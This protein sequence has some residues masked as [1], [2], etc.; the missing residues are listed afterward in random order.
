VDRYPDDPDLWYFWALLLP[1]RGLFL[2][3]PDTIALRRGAVGL[4]RVLALDSTYLEALEP[5]ARMTYQLGDTARGKRYSEQYLARAPTGPE[6]ETVRCMLAAGAR[7]LAA[8]PTLVAR[9][10]SLGAYA[11]RWCLFNLHAMP[12]AS[13]VRDSVADHLGRRYLAD[14][15][16]PGNDGMM[17]A[18][19]LWM[20][21]ADRGRPAEAVG[22][23][24]AMRAAGMGDTLRYLTSRI[25]DALYWEGDGE[26]ADRAATAIAEQVARQFAE[27]QGSHSP[28]DRI[29]VE[30]ALWALGQWR[31]DR[32]DT[33]SARP[34]IRQL[35]ELGG[36]AE[37]WED[38]RVL[39]AAEAL[40]TWYAAQ[41][42]S[43]DADA[44]ITRLDSL[45]RSVATRFPF[46]P[47]VHLILASLLEARGDY[48]DALRVL[49]GFR[50]TF[51]WGHAST[52]LRERGRLA[53]LAGDTAGALSAYHRYLAMRADPE[54]EV[55]PEVDRIRAEVARLT[56]G[57]S[58]LTR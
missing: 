16:I 41:T 37:T 32:G 33:A 30:D 2:G 27:R 25:S 52:V 53:L 14:P 12:T 50:A 42:R 47:Q 38:P 29:Q 46:V 54:P 15:G 44:R 17:L 11:A 49:S 48:G 20:V 36:E 4:E 45:V 22:Y 21:A 24:K 31:L 55:L 18:S 3:I 40:Q 57:R 5:L 7:G 23:L 8:L 1:N 56:T 51:A 35:R 13:A 34:I 10:D 6:A 39:V 9:L 43:P 26:A 19:S 28:T 58:E